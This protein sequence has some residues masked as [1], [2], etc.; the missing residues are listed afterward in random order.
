MRIAL[1]V[2]A[3]VATALL[4]GAVKPTAPADLAAGDWPARWVTE[5]SCNAIPCS[6]TFLF[7]KAFDLTRV[8]DRFPVRVSADEHYRLFVNGQALGHGPVRGMPERWFYDTYDLAPHLVVGRN[9]LGAEVENAGEH[10][11]WGQ[12]SGGMALIVQGETPESSAVNTD[13]TWRVR[14]DRDCASWRPTGSSS[15]S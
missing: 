7:R 13:G 5:A 8:P 6:G 9:V 11:A 4:T 15:P 1:G 3:L 10:R 2:A 12:V 14:L